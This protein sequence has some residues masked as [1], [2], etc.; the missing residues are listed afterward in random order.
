MTIRLEKRR[1]K[2]DYEMPGS[3]ARVKDAAIDWAFS[4]SDDDE[5]EQRRERRLTAAIECV[6]ARRMREAAEAIKAA[7][8]RPRIV[9]VVQPVLPILDHEPAI[10]SPTWLRLPKSSPNPP[11]RPSRARRAAQGV[12]G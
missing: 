7:R 4:D 8:R 12:H 2:W 10:A 1:T 11:R 3:V 6:V 5:D 9:L